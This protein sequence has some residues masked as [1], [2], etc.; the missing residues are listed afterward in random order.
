[1]VLIA[2]G[3]NK[4]STFTG[5]INAFNGNVKAMV[6]LGN[7]A[8]KIKR[9]AESLGF[10]NS[11]IMNNMDECV[12]KAY[13]LAEEGDTV[14]LSPA[15]ASWDMYDSFEQRGDHFKKCVKKLR[16]TRYE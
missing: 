4:N 14:L 12:N 1:M 2:G 13:E 15:C 8:S 5:F 7:T 9:E 10:K 6:L 3:Y 16:C 11:Y